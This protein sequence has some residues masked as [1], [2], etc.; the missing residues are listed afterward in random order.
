SEF[1]FWD[2]VGCAVC[3]LPFSSTD[4][5]SPLV[6]FWITECGHVVCNTH[7][8]PN[9]SCAKCGDQGI[10]LMPLQRNMELPMSDWFRSLPHAIDSMANAVK[11]QQE[12]LAALVRHYRSQCLQFSSTCDRLRNERRLL[13]KEAEAL[14]REVHQLRQYRGFGGEHSRYRSCRSPRKNPRQSGSNKT[15]SS[16]RSIVTPVGPLRLTRPPGEHPTFS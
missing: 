7:L 4:R 15:N 8:N 2:F 10:Q 5:G 16:P 6:P 13:R 1:D 11:F 14:R 12:S 3:H 9:Q